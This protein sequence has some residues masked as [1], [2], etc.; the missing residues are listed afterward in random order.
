[1]Y[2]VPDGTLFKC[3]FSTGIMSLLP[4]VGIPAGTPTTRQDLVEESALL[5]N[6]F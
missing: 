2:V 1:M 4:V 5:L 6:F 3:D